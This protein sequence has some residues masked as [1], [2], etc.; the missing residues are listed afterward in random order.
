M[1][2]DVSEKN[3]AFLVKVDALRWNMKEVRN[4]PATRQMSDPRV[5]DYSEI[6]QP[7]TSNT[8]FFQISRCR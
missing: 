4:T 1:A 8:Y 3:S 2:P 6:L 7:E 5:R